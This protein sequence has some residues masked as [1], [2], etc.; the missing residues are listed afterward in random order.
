[1]S[2]INIGCD[3]IFTPSKIE[4]EK[5][6][7]EIWNEIGESWFTNG[8]QHL[9]LLD[10][11]IGQS[12]N[13]RKVYILD[14]TF[15]IDHIEIITNAKNRGFQLVVLYNDLKV[16]YL[17]TQEQINEYVLAYVDKPPAARIKKY[18]N[19][20]DSTINRVVATLKMKDSLDKAIAQAGGEPSF[21]YNEKTTVYELLAKLSTNSI[22]FVYESP[23]D[24]I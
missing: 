9:S 7:K 14:S 12:G 23:V 4:F 24:G 20:E 16:H 19:N 1:M 21:V 8:I 5:I 15:G 10:Q 17:N 6:K 11:L 2:K 22:T 18:F 3:F 13:A